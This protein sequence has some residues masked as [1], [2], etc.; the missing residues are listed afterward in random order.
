MWYFLCVKYTFP[1]KRY[2]SDWK[3]NITGTSTCLLAS[4]GPFCRD[5]A[6]RVLKAFT[7]WAPGTSL[8]NKQQTHAS[9]SC[10][11]I[12]TTWSMRPP[13]IS[14]N[15]IIAWLPLTSADTQHWP[16]GIDSSWGCCWRP[17]APSNQWNQQSAWKVRKLSNC[18]TYTNA[19]NCATTT[20]LPTFSL[21]W[22]ASV[23]RKS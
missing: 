10:L 1:T 12:Q 3:K 23:S 11:M 14:S 21:S 8:D 15:Y 2:K 4:E 13:N 9:N 18:S 16:L 17:P 22:G 20:T 5:Q 19:S 7:T 6:D